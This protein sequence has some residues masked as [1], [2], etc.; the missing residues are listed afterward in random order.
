MPRI[1]QLADIYARK[2]LGGH[3]AGRL[4]TIGKTQQDL[5]TEL[6]VSQQTVSR[7]IATGNVTIE[8]LQQITKSVPLDERI[9]MKAAFPWGV[10]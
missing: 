2:D 8:Q 7:W 9:V 4:K 5:A 10:N 1:R 3:I 6:G